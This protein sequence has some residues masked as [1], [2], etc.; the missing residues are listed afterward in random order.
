MASQE[1][2][3]SLLKD[4]IHPGVE[5]LME[6]R[7]FSELRGGKLSV[8]RL[9]GFALQHY[10]HNESINRGFALCI[11]KNAHIPDLYEHFA[12]QFLEEYH[13]P[14][15]AKRFGL[16]LG[17][18]EDDFKQITPVFE[19]LAHTSAVL[20]GMLLGAAGENRTGALVNETMV[21]RY[22]SEFN[23]CLHKHYHLSSDDCQFFVV[24]AVADIEHTRLNAEI[25]ARYVQ[26]PWEEEASVACAKNMVRFKI[27]KF[28]GIYESY[29]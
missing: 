7:F 22:S 13:H 10:L 12:H 26:T 20:R 8:K 23:S 14:N 5:R 4:I 29:A 15:L 27:A 18:K 17:L 3:D 1:F 16:G 24:H 21:C 9:Q 25:I 11:V 19:C 28:D 6:T 2:I